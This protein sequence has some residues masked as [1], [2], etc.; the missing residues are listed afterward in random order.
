[1][2]FFCYKFLCIIFLSTLIIAC[3]VIGNA[4]P[5]FV[6]GEKFE[7]KISWLGIKAGSGSLE[8]AEILDIDGREVLHIKA[9]GD[10]IGLVSIICKIRDSMESY[11]DKEKQYSL[12]CIKDFR[13]GFYKKKETTRFDQE[14]HEAYVNEKTIEILPEAKD[15]FACLYY[16]R[17]QELVVGETVSLNAYDNRK[18][19]RLKVNVLKKE[20][21][22]IEKNTYETILI[23]PVLEGLNLEG[24]L[25][26]EDSKIKVW[27]TDD[28]RRIPVRVQMKI[29]FGSIVVEL[30]NSELP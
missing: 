22:K 8:L 6:E 4:Q 16:I 27:L 19:H 2:K 10:S 1:M 15:P 14:K 3:S 24:V 26:V 20:T 5:V 11:I 29:T 9:R 13:E 30:V 7:Y 28:E 21:I 25:K 17:A 23:E 12:K 18:D